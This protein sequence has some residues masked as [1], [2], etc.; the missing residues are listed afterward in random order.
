VQAKSPRESRVEMVELVLPSDANPL[1]TVFGGKVMQW[2]DVA[3]TIAAMRHCRHQV[4]TASMDA[5]QFHAPVRVGELAVLEGRVNAA[6]RTSMECGVTVHSENPLTGE[7]KL[8]TSALLT[9]VAVDASGR[10]APVVPP[11]AVESGEDRALLEQAL[12][13]RRSRGR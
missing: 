11:L 12:Q 8:C 4:V 6:F 5:L 3:A 7:R 10:P 13:R 1:D 2:I 9:F